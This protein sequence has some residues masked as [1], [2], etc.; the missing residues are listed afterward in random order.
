[1]KRFK[2]VNQAKRYNLGDVLKDDVDKWGEVRI[3]DNCCTF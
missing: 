2:V 1:M 3:N